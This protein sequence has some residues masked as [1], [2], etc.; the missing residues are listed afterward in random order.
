MNECVHTGQQ[1]LSEIL[2]NQITWGI[3][4]VWHAK[5]GLCFAN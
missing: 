1:E 2:L 3:M 5:L 4:N